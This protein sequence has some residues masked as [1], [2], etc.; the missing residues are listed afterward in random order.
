VAPW[1]GQEVLRILAPPAGA[2]ADW[3]PR[4]DPAAQVARELQGWREWS[5]RATP[6][7]CADPLLESQLAF[8]RIQQSC[9]GG[10]I[11]GVRR[12]AYSDIRDMHGA[13]RGLLAAA[14]TAIS[15]SSIFTC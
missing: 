13:C 7:V 8:I 12:Y 15:N 4:S 5:G 2:V 9:D 3:T 6:A 1:D 14:A 10:F 11:A